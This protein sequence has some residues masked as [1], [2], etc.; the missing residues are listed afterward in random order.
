MRLSEGI[1]LGAMMKP[2]A[3]THDEYPTKSCV[4]QAALDSIG[5]D[6]DL[7][8]QEGYET[9]KKLFPI[10]L[11]RVQRPDLTMQFTDEICSCMFVL[12]DCERWS[13]E[14]IAD[15]VES[16]ENQL[17]QQREAEHATEHSC[18]VQQS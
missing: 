6:G 11:M 2:Q 12:N 16:I 17:E 7:T 4:I 3:N 5:E 9:F 15:W 13:R 1:R 8:V 10:A 18:A 14:R